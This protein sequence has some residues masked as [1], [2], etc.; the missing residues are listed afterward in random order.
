[1]FARSC[2]IVALAGLA[3]V[4]CGPVAWSQTGA[5]EPVRID[6]RRAERGRVLF[7]HEW[8]EN[9]P[10]S[11]KGDGLGPMFNAKSCRECHW[12]S[13]SGGAGDNLNNVQVLSLV[14]SKELL[15]GN[16]FC[17][18]TSHPDVVGAKLST[19]FHR[20]G[21][22]ELYPYWRKQFLGSPR[23]NPLWEKL[24]SGDTFSDAKGRRSPV[25]RLPSINRQSF[26]ISQRNTPA[27][28]GAALIDAIPAAAIIAA[29]EENA[30]GA[31]QTNSVRGRV[32]RLPDGKIGRFGWRG[33]TESLSSFV[34]TACAVELGLS[35]TGHRQPIE[36]HTKIGRTGEDLSKDQCDDMIEFVA[37]LPRPKQRLPT[38]RMQR[39]A[40]QAGEAT[41][42]SFGCTACHRPDLGGVTGLY[43]DL[44]LHDMGTVLAD[45][46]AAPLP[47][48]SA[49][50]RTTAQREWRTP[51]LWG[52]AESAPYLHD[53]R[54]AT[55]EEAILLH[56]G[57]AESSITRYRQS[58]AISRAMVVSFLK[59]LE[60][61]FPW[62][63]LPTSGNSTW[64]TSSSRNGRS[65]CFGC[66]GGM[67]AGS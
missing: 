20:H 29:A 54:A 26:A 46:A 48:S 10:L 65:G 8:T 63:R 28:W 53:G 7:D 50:D 52:I 41:F 59:S 44:L 18:T 27:M 31:I 35:S 58:S 4:M 40:V 37:S 14:A 66:F 1:M 11:F 16:T 47:P 56:G 12:M 60:S 13:G 9:D 42:H 38:D 57:E 33:Q 67:S 19:V 2:S 55:L 36:P 25:V 21:L 61:P 23:T 30:R 51:P 24:V 22:D 5:L 49:V 64:G 17:A 6:E 15:A 32:A 3:V 62:Q 43:S 45:P 39:A 34:L